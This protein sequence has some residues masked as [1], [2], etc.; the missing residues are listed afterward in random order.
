MIWARS[1][2][3][4]DEDEETITPLK[5]KRLLQF[6]EIG[7]LLSLLTGYLS[8]SLLK[9]AAIPYIDATTSVFGL[10]AT[11]L[12]AHRYLSAWVFWIVLNFASAI[13]YFQRGLMVY[14]PLML[15]YFAFSIVGYMTWKKLIIKPSH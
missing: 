2:S 5:W 6:I 4:S 13:I 11:Y 15:I 14:A 9:D 7:I 10:I 1:D 3:A 8:K 12:E